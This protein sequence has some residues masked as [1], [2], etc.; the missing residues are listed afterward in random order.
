M[1]F[2]TSANQEGMSLIE[3]LIGIAIITVAFLLIAIGQVFSF[4][5]LRKSVELENARTFTSRILEDKYQE[6]IFKTLSASGTNTP[7]SKFQ[8]YL[9]CQEGIAGCSGTDIY[10][11]YTAHWR[12][13]NPKSSSKTSVDKEGL[14]RL[15]VQVEWKAKGKQHSFSLAKYLSCIY[16]VNSNGHTACPLPETP[17]GHN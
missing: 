9:A 11:H 5:S 13:T 7:K 17:Q 8:E 6:L 15:E 14:V 2:T 16:I 4:T 3:L 10:Q 12:L 1:K